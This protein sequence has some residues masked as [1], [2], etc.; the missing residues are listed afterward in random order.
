MLQNL[1][2]PIVEG[3]ADRADR[4]RVLNATSGSAASANATA[5]A[6]IV[7]TERD[8]ELIVVHVRAPEVLR[9]GRLAPTIV[10]QQRLSDPHA[11]GVLSTARQVAWAHGALARVILISGDPA[12][13][14]VS[15]ARELDVELVVIGATP[16]RAPSG[17]RSPDA[18]SHPARLAVP[19]SG[20]RARRAHT[21]TV[22]RSNSAGCVSASAKIGASSC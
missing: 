15:L 11:N 22:L 10:H 9:V 21:G 16:S 4:A 1:L 20:C 12:P 3:A 17:N 18:I 13:A 2:E 8:A 6:A 19:R 7:A 14:I 5:A